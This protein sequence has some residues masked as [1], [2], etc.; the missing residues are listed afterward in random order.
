MYDFVPMCIFPGRLGFFFATIFRRRH[1]PAFDM[2]SVMCGPSFALL[3]VVCCV[4]GR[5]CF[6]DSSVLFRLSGYYDHQSVFQ[7]V[8]WCLQRLDSLSPSTGLDVRFFSLWKETGV[9]L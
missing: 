5:D 4:L 2:T 7:F 8:L 3:W 6:A 1:W 9:S